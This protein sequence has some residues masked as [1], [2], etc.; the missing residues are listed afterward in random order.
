MSARPT[1]VAQIGDLHLAAPGELAFGR[2]DTAAMLARAVA[3]LNAMAPRP[4]LVVIAGDIAQRDRPEG[5]G[6]AR[7]LLADLAMPF[8]LT[9]GNHDRRESLRAA[10]PGQSFAHPE[11]LDSV[12]AAG[13]LD[14]ILLDSSLPG[15]PHGGLDVGALAWLDAALSRDPARPALV[16]LHHPPCPVGIWHVDARPFEGADGL[17]AIVRRHR[18]VRLVAAAHAHRLIATAFAGV[19]AVV[20]PALAHAIAPDPDRSLPPSWSDAPPGLLLHVWLPDAGRLV[21]HQV[22]LAEGT[23][24]PLKPYFSTKARSTT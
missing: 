1:L 23:S 19:P 13:P 14:V 12:T 6:T 22:P 2:F 8:V 10:F 16:V 24:G 3:M 11:R 18:R 21:T 4:D 9:V 15:H 5:Y 17:E 20:A 7:A